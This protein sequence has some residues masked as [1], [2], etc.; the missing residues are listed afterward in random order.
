MKVTLLILGIALGAV[1]LLHIRGIVA[2]PDTMVHDVASPPV[3]K[4]MVLRPLWTLKFGHDTS[5]GSIFTDNG[6]LYVGAGVATGGIS[7]VRLNDGHVMWSQKCDAYQPSY[8]V[9]NG[10]VVIVG[11]YYDYKIIGL[12]NMTGKQLWSVPTKVE[13]KSAACFDDKLAY[14]GSYDTNLYAIKWK[15]GDIRWKRKLGDMIWSTPVIS[16]NLLIV[17]CYDGYLYFI[18]KVTGNVVRKVDCGGVIR[19][20]PVL[21]NNLAFIAVGK[22]TFRKEKAAGRNLT[23]HEQEVIGTERTR[24]LIIDVITGR[25]VSSITTQNRFSEHVIT[26][27]EQAYF[28]DRSSLY[29]YN[30]KQRKI[31]WS[32]AVP[33][34]FMPFPILTGNAVALPFS[35]LGM[36][37]MKTLE[38]KVDLPIIHLNRQ[39]GK[40][41]QKQKTGG[42]SMNS[43]LIL[44]LGKMIITP[45]SR[46]QAFSLD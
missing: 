40:I 38:R 28:F 44:Q 10:K 42:V 6:Y 23:F 7:K 4:D 32:V 14:I 39:N 31:I 20:N 25:I 2:E 36:D 35:Y 34:N 41:I 17:G 5:A 26:D 43:T 29:C 15:T 1:S 9:S 21:V 8:P 37:C 11:K 46:V 45:D 30:T 22:K 16:K 18:D 33:S 3:S 12:D 13:N 19:A 24:M 27:G